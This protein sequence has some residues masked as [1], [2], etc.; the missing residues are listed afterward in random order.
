MSKKNKIKQTVIR[1]KT[2]TKQ[3]CK[4]VYTLFEN[5]SDRVASYRL[6]LYSIRIDLI[7][8]DG[9]ESYAEVSDVFCDIGKA[10]V[11]YEMLI[12]NL[13]TPIDL[14]YILEDK[15]SI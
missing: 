3:G 5:E 4:Y 15:I 14:P 6:S 9:K 12:K 2:V 8:A 1:T 10:M 7:D 13:A 11:F